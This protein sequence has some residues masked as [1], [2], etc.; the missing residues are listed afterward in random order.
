MEVVFGQYAY[1]DYRVWLNGQEMDVVHFNGS[2]AHGNRPNTQHLCSSLL[3]TINE[4]A[5]TKRMFEWEFLC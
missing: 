4:D 3:I 2:T 1:A 5:W